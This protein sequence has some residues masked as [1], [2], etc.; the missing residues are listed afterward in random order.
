MSRIITKQGINPEI[1]SPE[2]REE[3]K[4]YLENS[5]INNSFEIMKPTESVINMKN[6]DKDKDNDKDKNNT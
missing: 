3:I 1:F 2:A 4:K 5:T 6:K